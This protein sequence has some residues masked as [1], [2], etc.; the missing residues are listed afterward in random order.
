MSGSLL[1]IEFNRMLPLIKV[2]YFV[3][4]PM[5]NKRL[6]DNHKLGEKYETI[7]TLIL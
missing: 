2:E 5:L 4:V 1:F 3:E 7:F 6:H